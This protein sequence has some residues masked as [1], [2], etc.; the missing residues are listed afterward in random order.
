MTLKVQKHP[1]F[2]SVLFSVWGSS[3]AYLEEGG[4]SWEGLCLRGSETGDLSVSFVF[5]RH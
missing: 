3:F 5:A 4:A 2:P 1:D